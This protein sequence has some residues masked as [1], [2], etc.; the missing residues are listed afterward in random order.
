[1]KDKLQTDEMRVAV[2]N[3][4]LGEYKKLIDLLRAMPF[5]QESFLQALMFFD[6]GILWVKEAVYHVPFSQKSDE[7]VV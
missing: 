3:S 7:V 5:P 4:F 6:T 2:Y 1:M